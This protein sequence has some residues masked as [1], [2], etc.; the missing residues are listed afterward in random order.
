M[1]ERAFFMLFGQ[2]GMLFVFMCFGSVLTARHRCTDSLENKTVIFEYGYY[3]GYR[4]SSS[5]SLV[6]DGD[7]HENDSW[8]IT[9]CGEQVCL[10]SKEG[11]LTVEKDQGIQ[12][13]LG[14]KIAEAKSN[15]DWSNRFD[16]KCIDCEKGEDCQVINKY[17][18]SSK[19]EEK[20]RMMADRQG[21]VQFGYNYDKSYDQW[22][23]WKIKILS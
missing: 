22:F 2:L 12:N 17:M 7:L 14:V 13:R 23:D 1:R 4:L 5:A 19:R 11:L 21:W 15:E 9:R 6:W 10:R 16:I 3:P 18:G 8:K 20:G